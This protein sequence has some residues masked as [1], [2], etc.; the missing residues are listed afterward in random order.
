MTG[1]NDAVECQH[2]LS[3]VERRG[4]PDWKNNDQTIWYYGFCTECGADVEV[5]YEFNRT[6]E[7]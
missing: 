3:D 5:Q 6:T 1:K 7:R 2:D 4:K